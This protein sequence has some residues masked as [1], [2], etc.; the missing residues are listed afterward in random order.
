[1]STVVGEPGPIDA[2]ERI[3]FLDGLRG[4]ALFGILIANMSIFSGWLLMNDVQRSAVSL[5]TPDHWFAFG[6]D[7][8]VTGK[9]YGL[10]SLLFGVGFTLQLQRLETR[11]DGH[12]LYVRRM[13]FLL[14]IGLA[15][16]L[17][18]WIGDILALYA[19]MG[20]L[21]LLF[22]N[23]S[24]RTILGWAAG[25]WLFTIAWAVI[26]L[27]TGFS[28]WS[29][30]WPLVVSAAEM[31]G[32]QLS[33]G[34]PLALYQTAD[35]AM[36]TRHHLPE[37]VMRYIALF[38]EMRFT[39]VLGLFLVGMWLGRHRFVTELDQHRRL[40]AKVA[41]GGL[42]IGLPMAALSSAISMQ[43][44][45]TE[46]PHAPVIGALGFAFGT[47]ALT[48]AYAAIAGLLWCD[49]E[50]FMMSM[51]APA[52]RMTLTNYI[53]QTVIQSVLFLGWGFG[54]MGRIPLV[55]IV[56][57]SIAIFAIQVG[58]SMWWL[59]RYRFGPLEWL[60]RSL[61]YGEP[62][63]LRNGAERAVA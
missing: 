22:R 53:M 5:G 28:P 32:V 35:L 19:M 2:V 15:H 54:L 10:F 57:I 21:L 40:L 39:K 6:L 27:A 26:K 37:A 13:F 24:D 23:A 16:L 25:L 61:T 34:G 3:P 33:P 62:Q 59:E 56:P 51:F 1:M 46:I 18:L 20:F 63:P 7:W 55:A 49:G 12:Q 50:R 4:F 29:A 60:W 30:G 8:L 45:M 58:F 14:L 38:D 43:L 11:R 44:I 41:A 52:G 36:Q 48:F 17:L 47:P 9:F 31:A 42:M